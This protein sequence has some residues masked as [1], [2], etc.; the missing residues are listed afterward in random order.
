[1]NAKI[2]LP[3]TQATAD[4][5]VK[6]LQLEGMTEEYIFEDDCHIY[7]LT[8]GQNFTLNASTGDWEL[9]SGEVHDDG[10]D[11]V[12][13]GSILDRN[14]ESDWFLKTFGKCAYERCMECMGCVIRPQCPI[15]SRY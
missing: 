8:T 4:A 3:I 13:S 1:M 14:A 12:F 10:T 15:A 9:Y 2:R 7:T 6:E 5:F 11:I